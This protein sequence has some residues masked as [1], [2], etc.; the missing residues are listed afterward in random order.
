MKIR[1]FLLL[2]LFFGVFGYILSKLDLYHSYIGLSFNYSAILLFFLILGFLSPN[3]L[4]TASLRNKLEA[5]KIANNNLVHPFNIYLN[6]LAAMFSFSLGYAVDELLT[7]GKISH[8]II[9]FLLFCIGGI[10]NILLVRNKNSDHKKVS[11][12]G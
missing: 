3:V 9:I 12:F 1:Y 4:L 6:M 2:T 5:G 11:D 7:I 8:L 10:L